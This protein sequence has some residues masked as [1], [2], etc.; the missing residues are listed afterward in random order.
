[1][2]SKP[3]QHLLPTTPQ[4]PPHKTSGVISLLHAL[5]C[6]SVESHHLQLTIPVPL[7]S[8]SISLVSFPT[9]PTA[10]SVS[11]HMELLVD[12]YMCHALLP[13][14]FAQATP[15]C[16]VICSLHSSLGNSLHFLPRSSFP[17]NSIVPCVSL[18]HGPYH[19][20]LHLSVYL[21]ISS[22]ALFP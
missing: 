9:L 8:A 17:L 22:T 13:L 7:T 11:S 21:D 6:F 4:H 2:T 15:F 16:L 12:A 18:S 3:S 20:A 10:T 19:I 1:M 5:Q 14:A